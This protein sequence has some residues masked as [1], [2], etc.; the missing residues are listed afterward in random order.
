MLMTILA[1]TFFT[2]VSRHL[3]S[4]MFLSVWHKT[5]MFMMLVPNYFCNSFVK[6]G[7]ALNVTTL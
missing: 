6:S 3:V 4:L 7:E 1:Q 5:M 2:F